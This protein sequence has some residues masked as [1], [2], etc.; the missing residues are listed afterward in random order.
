YRCDAQ[1]R[2]RHFYRPRQSEDRRQRGRDVAKRTVGAKLQAAAVFRD[3]NERHGICGVIRVRA[4]GD[5]IDH[6]LRVAVIGGDDPSATT[7]TQSLEN[8]AETR[9]Y[10]FAGL[11]SRFELAGET[12]HVRIRKIN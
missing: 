7:R 3:E 11:D 5:W 2:A 12:D 9:V 8:P 1:I 10:G 4:A 6:R